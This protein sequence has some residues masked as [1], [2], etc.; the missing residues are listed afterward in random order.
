MNLGLFLMPSHPPERDLR[1]GQGWD[2]EMLRMADELGYHEAWIGEHFTAPWEPNPAPDLLIAQALMQTRRIKLASGAHLLPY[3]HPAELACRVAFMDHLAQGRYMFGIGAGG[4]PSDSKLFQVEGLNREMTR[5]S[6]DMILKIWESDGGFEHQGKFW[7]VNVPDPM[8][9]TLRHH[10]KPFQKPHPPI[11][12]AGMSPGSETLKLAGE[13]GFIPMTL[14]LSSQYAATHWEAVLEGA[15]RTG[16]KPDRRNWRM[17]RETLVADTDEE[18][19]EACINGA[20]GRMMRQYLLPL[21]TDV[22]M[23][24]YMKDDPNMADEKLTP[25]YLFDH[26]WLVGSV[27][28]V[29]QKLEEMYQSVGGFG[30]L[31]LLGF[32]YLDHPA[33]WVKSMRL[34]ANEVLPRFMSSGIEQSSAAA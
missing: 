6:L 34:M 4:L 24:Q 12:V 3:H 20:M 16:R 30:T 9:R 33:P 14:N 18:A 23:I 1:A 19:Y 22:G 13:R 25:E 11:G 27:K 5:E 28:T 26:G 8:M 32:D 2:L 21:M 29:T 15:D 10:L 17:V 31:L 7:K